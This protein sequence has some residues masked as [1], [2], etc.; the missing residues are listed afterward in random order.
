MAENLK[1]LQA[2]RD[3]MLAAAEA[4]QKF[5]AGVKKGADRA[6]EVQKIMEKVEEIE[7]KIT[8]FKEKQLPLMNQAKSL[9]DNLK[10]QQSELSNEYT[11]QSSL[12][13]ILNTQAAKFAGEN[14]KT[15]NIVKTRTQLG[16]IDNNLSKAAL[17][18][19]EQIQSGNVDLNDLSSMQLDKSAAKNEKEEALIDAINEAVESQAAFLEGTNVINKATKKLEEGF[20]KVRAALT[21]TAI[22]GALVGVAKS[23]GATIDAI[24]QKFGNLSVMGEPFKNDLLDASVEATKLGGGIEDVAAIT[25]TLASNF[26]MNVDEAAKLSG[27]VFDTSKAIGLSADEGANLFGVLTQTAN[28]SAEQAESL[29]E[30]A[31]QLARQNGVAPNA[32]MADIAGSA[33]E[34]AVF[35]KDGGE[36]IAEAAVQARKMG[37][38]LST[39]AKIA[40]GLLD[41][42]SSIQNEI[43]ASVLVGKQ[44]NY[45][46]AR[47]LA[48]N[49]DIAGAVKSVVDQLG[50]E[51]EFNNLNAIAR[52]SIAKSIGV[53]V[54]E[55][56]KLVGQSDKLSLSGAMAAG[57][58]EDLLGQDGISNISS[59][60]NKFKSLGA[61]LINELG[62]YMESILGQLNRF[63]TEGKGIEKIQGIIQG[64][65][66]AFQFVANNLPT[67]IALMVAFKTIS[68][69]AAIASTIAAIAGSAAVTPLMLGAGG[70]IAG[71]AII[72]SYYAAKSALKVDDFTSGPGGITHMS[73]PA[74][75]FELNPKD[76]VLATTNPI[77]VNDMMTGP[78]GSMGG[79][80]KPQTINI[81]GNFKAKG[82]VMEAV[83]EGANNQPGYNSLQPRFG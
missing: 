50:S 79:N 49:N 31:F 6:R 51:E 7:N 83:L 5:G 71:A 38:S 39:T 13:K 21:M 36:N 1:D 45:Q 65:G 40:E 25:S 55:M 74:G 54:A 35:T 43:E 69:G 41:F 27:K 34:I 17:S 28:L 75:S 16:D 58:F 53:S 82:D 44:L 72:A 23:F 56:S 22:F 37:L 64:L 48:L 57:N 24:G 32:V 4:A 11:K 18:T 8:I 66:S 77:A 12:S 60:I 59:L 61:T 20:N 62:P 80:D 52:Q 33:E 9:A 70:A 29:A 30:G 47:E 73:G 15:A 67:V 81:V 26:G 68:L 76:S 14:K 3:A 42:E 46:K 78:A 2:Q 19:L 63:L 10:K